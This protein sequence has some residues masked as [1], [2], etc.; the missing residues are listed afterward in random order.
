MAVYRARLRAGERGPRR[1]HR[2]WN[3][4]DGHDAHLVFYCSNA[5]C[6]KAPNAAHR[7]KERATATCVS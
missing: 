4:A 6:R 2:N 7:A 3:E 1:T 5:L